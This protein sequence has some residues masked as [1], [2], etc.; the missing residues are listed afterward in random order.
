MEAAAGGRELERV[1]SW[2]RIPPLI[3]GPGAAVLFVAA[4]KS[5]RRWVLPLFWVALLALD[6]ATTAWVAL[7]RDFL[8]PSDFACMLTPVLAVVT[9]L[10][11]GLARKRVDRH[12]GEDEGR[13]KWYEVGMVV[14]PSLQITMMQLM[15][16]LETVLCELGIITCS[17]W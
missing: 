14:I 4:I 2:W 8:G 3:S 13:R 16:M 1:R 9:L 11:L 10:A 6:F 5:K 15:L 17:D 7:S 12:L